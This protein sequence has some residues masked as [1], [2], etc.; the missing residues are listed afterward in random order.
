[1]HLVTFANVHDLKKD[2]GKEWIKYFSRQN[3]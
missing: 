3:I 2:N 1:M